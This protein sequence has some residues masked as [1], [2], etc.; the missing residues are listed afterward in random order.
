MSA[1]QGKTALITGASRGIGLA[2]ARRFSAEGARVALCA[3]RLGAHG[4]LPGTLEDAV[5]AIDAAGGTA[6]ALVC[7][8]GDAAARADLVTRAEEALGPLDILVN[9][10]AGAKMALPSAVTAAERS[11]MYELNL[12]APIDLAQQALPGM[13]QRGRGWILNI[14]SSTC[15]QPVVPYRD[16]PV[17]AHVIAAYG[18]TKAALNRYSEGLAHEV[19][20]EGV[21]VN[22]LAPES[23]VL[24]PGAEQVRDIARRHPDMAEPVEMMA[25]AALVLCSQR[26]VGRTA[27]SRRLLHALGRPVHSLDGRTVLGDAFLPADLGDDND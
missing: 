24:T 22:T 18:A 3:S 20:A 12:N 8:L 7:D 19:A 26:H 27:Y 2:I 11:W 17:A 9:N 21:C 23:I 6:V 10:A 13:R 14:S 16:S 5:A 15:D 25:E 1:L 4:K